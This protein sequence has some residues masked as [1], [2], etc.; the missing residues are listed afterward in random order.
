MADDSSWLKAARTRAGGPHQLTNQEVVLV[1]VLLAAI[2]VSHAY[3]PAAAAAIVS[4]A[5]TLIGAFFVN[6]NANKGNPGGD[7]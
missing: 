2:I 7:A 4:I 6:R 5:S 3:A 1:A